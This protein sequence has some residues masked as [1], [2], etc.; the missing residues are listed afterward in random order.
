MAKTKQEQLKVL[1][2]E[3]KQAEAE[4]NETYLNYIIRIK[5]FTI[6]VHPGAAV[7]MNSGS[8]PPPP[9]YGGGG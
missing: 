9:P 1:D 6:N 3:I 7:Y 5:E 4:E 8:P 2:A